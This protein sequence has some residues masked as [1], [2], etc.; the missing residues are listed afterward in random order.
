MAYLNNVRDG[1]RSKVYL[2]EFGTTAIS[3]LDATTDIGKLFCIL[4][5]DSSASKFGNLKV[6]DFFICLDIG[7][8]TPHV[9]AVVA[10]G[11]DDKLVS[12]TPKFLGGATDKDISFEK[13]TQEVTCDKDEA[14]NVVSPGTVAI[15]GSVTAYDLLQTGDTAA[16]RIKQKFNKMITLN[17]TTGIPTGTELDR[18]DKD[19]LMFVWDAREL[20]DGEYVGIDFVPAFISSQAHGS[21]YG[22]GQTFT[23]NFTG[24]DTDEAGH[25]RSYLQFEYFAEFG[26]QLA[27]WDAN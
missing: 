27:A 23:L 19:V 22:S 18:T 2:L 21:S 1:R 15:S 9:P 14:Q 8:G 10:L 7:T 17:T 3:A 25:R 11:T 4:E 5:K 12:V 16:N 24:A 20:N 6:G 26:T 13:S